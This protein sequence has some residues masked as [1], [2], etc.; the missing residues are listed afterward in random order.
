VAQS[1][2]QLERGDADLREEG[3]D[4][5]GDEKPDAY[6]SLLSVGWI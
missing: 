6:V 1:F 4:V 3:I 5:A 2:E